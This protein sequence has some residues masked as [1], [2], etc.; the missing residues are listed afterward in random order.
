MHAKY[1]QGEIVEVLF[2]E[3]GGAFTI[4]QYL[5]MEDERRRPVVGGEKGKTTNRD[6]SDE[7]KGGEIL[8]GIM[9]EQKL[10]WAEMNGGGGRGTNKKKKKKKRWGCWKK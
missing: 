3:D 8:S 2:G 10:L 1:R 6:R 5:R 4:P 9:G 7:E